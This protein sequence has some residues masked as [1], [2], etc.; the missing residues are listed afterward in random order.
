MGLDTL[1]MDPSH[2]RRKDDSDTDAARAA[3]LR[4]TAIVGVALCS[5]SDVTVLAL[6]VASLTASGVGFAA[7][8]NGVRFAWVAACLVG[9]VFD[10]VGMF[11]L[12]EGAGRKSV[13][14]WSASMMRVV[15]AN[16]VLCAVTVGW[17]AGGVPAV[18][19]GLAFC[20]VLFYL[21]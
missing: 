21:G 3:A 5:L 8:S 15:I 7:A 10:A 20:A 12:L 18:A 13:L 16:P 11:A 2:A 9:M 14:M 17:M 1:N 6:S 19:L 4:R